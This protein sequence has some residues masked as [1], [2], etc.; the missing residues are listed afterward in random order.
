MRNMLRRNRRY[1][2]TTKM[3]DQEQTTGETSPFSGT[4]TITWDEDRGSPRVEIGAGVTPAM[5]YGA[6]GCLGM[7]AD[8]NFARGMADQETRAGLISRIVKPS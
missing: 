1:S 3:N 6:A 8:V 5:I 4:I 7:I 2:E